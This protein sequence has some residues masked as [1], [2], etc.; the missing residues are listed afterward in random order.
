[1]LIKDTLF[2]SPSSATSGPEDVLF[3]LLQD[4]LEYIPENKQ[5]YQ[6]VPEYSEHFSFS[7]T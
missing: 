4:I 7:C 1:M 3:P 6:I 5:T 2:I